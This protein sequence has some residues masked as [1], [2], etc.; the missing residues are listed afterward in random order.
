MKKI[1][2]ILLGFVFFLSDTLSGQEVASSEMKSDDKKTQKQ[3]QKLVYQGNIALKEKKNNQA[4]A[5]YREAISHNKNN[6]T[7]SYNMGDLFYEKA[8]YKEAQYFFNE[9]AMQK[10]ASKENKHKAFHNMGNVYM[11]EKQYDKA[12]M[13]YK[14]ALRNNP[15]DEETR[16]N[17]AVAKK[18]LKENP[19]ENKNDQDKDKNNQNKGGDDKNKEND[20][21]NKGNN[22]KNKDADD[23]NKENQDKNKDANNPNKEDGNQNKDNQN[24][25]KNNDNQD[26][27]QNTSG[28]N[29]PQKGEISPEQAERIL[30]AMNAQERKTQEKI[31][32]QKIK[33]SPVRSEKDW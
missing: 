25:N 4:E 17:L 23:K 3:F 5:Y 10:N 28:G 12:V 6:A 1:I 29:I 14:E 16:Y 8:S 7:A 15:F 27:R 30:E 22:D 24:Q 26:K 19:P 31:N 33:G 20:N 13:T 21:Q 11:K 9:A 32:A 18:F 2:Y